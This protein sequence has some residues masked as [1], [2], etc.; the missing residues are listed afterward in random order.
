[1][2]NKRLI[3]QVEEFMNKL[4]NEWTLKEVEIKVTPKYGDK[5]TVRKEFNQDG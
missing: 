2:I 1:M 3:N 5:L 4:G